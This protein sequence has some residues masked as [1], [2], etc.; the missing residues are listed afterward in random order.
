MRR[1]QG[2]LSIAMISFVLLFLFIPNIVAFQQ[3][4]TEISPWAT[5]QN[6]PEKE[7]TQPATTVISTTTN[8]DKQSVTNLVTTQIAQ[9]NGTSSPANFSISST[10]RRPS[11]LQIVRDYVRRVA[12]RVVE[13]NPIIAFNK[14]VAKLI[15]DRFVEYEYYDLL[16]RMGVNIT[17]ARRRFGNTRRRIT[18]RKPYTISSTIKTPSPTYK[19]TPTIPSSTTDSLL[20]ISDATN[21]PTPQP[22]API[23]NHDFTTLMDNSDS[24][25]EKT[26]TSVLINS[27]ISH[28][29]AE[30]PKITVSTDTSH[31]SSE[32]SGISTTLTPVSSTNKFQDPSTVVD[33]DESS[34]RKS[35]F[36][37]GFS[38]ISTMIGD[39][40]TTI[41]IEEESST[42]RPTKNP[43]TSSLLTTEN[44]GDTTKLDD[45]SPELTSVEASTT[46]STSTELEM[47][48][49]F[50]CSG[51][52]LFGGSCGHIALCLNRL[53]SRDVFF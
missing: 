32:R 22:L 4:F 2:I 7:F 51:E 46:F 14:F 37:T 42:T 30:D 52:K 29:L 6:S 17:A 8:S 26:T 3:N 20:G 23:G 45:S 43:V 40:G 38:S 15:V 5:K 27:T 47:Q 39:Q 41:G 33:F 25:P 31:S 11:R 44:Q 19:S 48:K 10:T 9:T 53:A 16:K 28:T 49:N 50:Y 1:R 13:R 36:T 21:T 35:G 18:T 24:S 12:N 34:T